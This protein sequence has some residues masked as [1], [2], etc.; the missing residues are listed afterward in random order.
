MGLYIYAEN[1]LLH[2]LTLPTVKQSTLV[3][4]TGYI[5]THICLCHKMTNS[6][7]TSERSNHYIHI[8]KE[9]WQ[10]TEFRVVNITANIMLSLHSFVLKIIILLA[11]HRRKQIYSFSLPKRLVEV[12]R[13]SSTNYMA[14]RVWKL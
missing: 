8:S 9:M 5:Q 6:I 2:K 3:L 13:K 4:S 1:L 10:Q 14:L 12:C 11:S 7:V